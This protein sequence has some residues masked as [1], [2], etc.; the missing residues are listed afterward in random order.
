MHAVAV[1]VIN[2]PHMSSCY[3]INFQL[4]AIREIVRQHNTNR[5]QL[6][7]LPQSVDQNNRVQIMIENWSSWHAL[8]AI[9]SLSVI[10]STNDKH[11]KCGKI[12][13]CREFSVEYWTNTLWIGGLLYYWWVS[14]RKARMQVTVIDAI[15]VCCI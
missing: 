2:S 6:Y 3:T 11:C 1:A 4:C 13:D 15:S 10:Y 7:K 12:N 9:L 5:L 8:Y 14:N